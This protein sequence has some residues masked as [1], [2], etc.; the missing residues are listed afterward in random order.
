MTSESR[1]NYDLF[2][3]VWLCE[4]YEED[5]GG[6]IVD[7]PDSQ[8]HQGI[9]KLMGDDLEQL[10][11]AQ[12][13]GSMEIVPLHLKMR[14]FASCCCLEDCEDRNVGWMDGGANAR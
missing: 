2:F 7:I 1:V 10:E 4:F 8:R 13:F 12:A 3:P 14:T 11:G 6:E 5:F 9:G